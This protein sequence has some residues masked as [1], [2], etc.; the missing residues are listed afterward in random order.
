MT[1]TLKLSQTRLYVSSALFV[2]ANIALPH[3]FHLIPGGGVMFLPIYFFTLIAA[4]RYGVY[5]GVLTAVMT[6][7]MGYAL[8]GAPMAAMI[9]DML[10]KGI[11]LSV[12]SCLIVRKNGY[13]LLS[14]LCSVLAAWTIVG[15]AELPMMGTAYAFQDF[16]TGLPGMAMMVLGSWIMVKVGSINSLRN[17]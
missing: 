7:L 16:V 4:M 6:P 5:A 3:L 11:V 14:S 15:I 1:N 9:P 2:A 12:V 10:L 8:F 13:S 17:V